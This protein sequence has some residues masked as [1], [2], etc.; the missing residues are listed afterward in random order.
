M[1]YIHNRYIYTQASE[2]E[3]LLF[4]IWVNLEGMRISDA[5][6]AKTDTV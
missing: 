1:L 5:S 3:I 2:K 6:Q 4:I